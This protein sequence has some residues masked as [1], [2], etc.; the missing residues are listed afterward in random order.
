V[1]AHWDTFRNPFG[2]ESDN[3][4]DDDGGEEEKL[5]EDEDEMGSLADFIVNDSDEEI[6]IEEDTS[7]E[8]EEEGEEEE[9]EDDDDEDEPE[10]IGNY[11]V[12][13][14]NMNGKGW[15]D[16]PTRF[17]PPLQ[18]GM[19]YSHL[20][21]VPLLPL[22]VSFEGRLAFCARKNLVQLCANENDSQKSLKPID[23]VTTK[24]HKPQQ[25]MS[26][27]EHEVREYNSFLQRSAQFPPGADGA[28]KR[29]QQAALLAA[30]LSICDQDEHLHQRLAYLFWRMQ[31]D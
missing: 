10:D 17:P 3:D 2:D 22:P 19:D 16:S 25:I 6:E 1:S 20:K 26:L 14:E 28:T 24:Y 30:A 8:E 13:Q 7:E 29:E 15:G 12:D 21:R 18:E 23:E 5:N 9:E 4:E 27:T 11:E 31:D